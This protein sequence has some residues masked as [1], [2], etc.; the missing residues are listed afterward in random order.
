MDN[1][2]D[3]AAE[4]R[5]RCGV[6][7]DCKW[8]R[9]SLAKS[10]RPIRRG[11]TRKQQSER[12]RHRLQHGIGWFFGASVEAP[13]KRP[14]KDLNEE[15]QDLSK[16]ERVWMLLRKGTPPGLLNECLELQLGGQSS[17]QVHSAQPRSSFRTIRTQ[18]RSQ[19]LDGY[20]SRG[21]RKRNPLRR[22]NERALSGIDDSL[23]TKDSPCCV[24]II[25]LPSA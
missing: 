5:W 16:T 20:A 13:P 10:K 24:S 15:C 4:P 18:S 8:P 2:L 1:E 9:S 12:K 7:G 22:V 14:S 6:I 11:H 3:W 21:A 17:P 25:R 19:S 23:T